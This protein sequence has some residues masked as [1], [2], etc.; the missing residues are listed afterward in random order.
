MKP[1]FVLVE[2]DDGL[3][4]FFET[5]YAGFKFAKEQE[6]RR[7]GC[8]EY[9]AVGEFYENEGT[10]Y[11]GQELRHLLRSLDNVYG[12]LRT[13]MEAEHGSAQD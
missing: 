6:A 3:Q 13:Q 5:P 4:E 10:I 12:W 9:V 7:K 1:T 11:R 2:L 8:V